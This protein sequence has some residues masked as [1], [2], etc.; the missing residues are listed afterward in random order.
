MDETKGIGKYFSGIFYNIPFEELGIRLSGLFG[1]GLGLMAALIFYF[2]DDRKLNA[3]MKKMEDGK[4]G[5]S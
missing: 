2:F 5:K 3:T 1:F 4:E